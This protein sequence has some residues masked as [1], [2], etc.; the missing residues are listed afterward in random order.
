MHGRDAHVTNKTV[1]PEGTQSIDVGWVRSH[2]LAMRSS[3]RDFIRRTLF[4]AAIGHLLPC[5]ASAFAKNESTPF[6]QRRLGATGADVSILG[7]GLGGA[8]MDGYEHN[9]DGERLA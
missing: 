8:F 7:L 2:L 4:G 5:A 6:D 3:R 1:Q 9:T